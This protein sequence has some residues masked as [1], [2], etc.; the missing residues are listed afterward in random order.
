MAELI[1]VHNSYPGTGPP[2]V[3]R[4]IGHD[5]TGYGTY[6]GQYCPIRDWYVWEQ[7]LVEM[8][9]FGMRTYNGR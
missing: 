9:C 8:V 1:E 2:W 7:T 5:I 6:V 3:L 4:W